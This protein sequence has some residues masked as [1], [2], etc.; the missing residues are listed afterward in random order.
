MEAVDLILFR[1]SWKHF[2]YMIV[3]SIIAFDIKREDFHQMKQFPLPSATL[4]L[5]NSYFI[6]E[7]AATLHHIK[8]SNSYESEWLY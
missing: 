8:K 2:G 5:Q 6:S 3:F 1:W 7:I 4:P